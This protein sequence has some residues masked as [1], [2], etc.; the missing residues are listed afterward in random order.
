MEQRSSKTPADLHTGFTYDKPVV[1]IVFFLDPPV[2]R[3]MRVIE[4]CSK[5]REI[6]DGRDE[7]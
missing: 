3:E 5:V 1:G 6:R 7:N 4:S 2:H